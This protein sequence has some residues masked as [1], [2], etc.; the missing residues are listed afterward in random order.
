[1]TR[2]HTPHLSERQSHDE[3]EN[4]IDSTY[5]PRTDLAMEA[6]QMAMGNATHVS[7]VEEHSQDLDG[8]H[9]SRVHV[10]N[11]KG[12]RAIGKKKGNYITLEAAGLR[13]RDPDLQERMAEAFA[14]EFKDILHIP[15]EAKVL[16]VGLGNDQVTPD[17]LGPKVVAK[18][19][20]TRH[21]FNYFPDLLG[22]GY[23]AVCAVSPGV[24]GV[25]GLETSEVVKG[26]VEHVQ[27]DV[28]IAIDALASRSLSRVNST[29]QITDTGIQPGA[30]VGNK[31]KALDMENLGCKVYAVGV[32]TVVDA[33]TIANDSMDL[34][35][36]HLKDAVPSNSASQIFDQ[37]HANE[38]WQLI[39]EVL[40]PLGNNLMVTP[41][42]IDEFVD[43][44]AKVVAIGLNLALHPGITKEEA[45]TLTH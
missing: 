12:E 11:A 9:I 8:I 45:Q 32:P 21:I 44:I 16:V 4:L 2:R 36:K 3:T 39:R 15:E 19:F 31:R 20:V 25:T 29:V 18:L 22:E 37:F 27:P 43:D 26:I 33:A 14:A 40:E 23:R 1:M 34:V 13:R 28:V 6:H 24:L 5:S 41:K 17:A 42:E 30:G 7:G 35:L 38:K 10:M